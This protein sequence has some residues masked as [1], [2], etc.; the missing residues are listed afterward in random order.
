MKV[1]QVLIIA[2]VLLLGW[3]NSSNA[4]G[5]KPA[6][7][8][9]FGFAAS[10]ND[11]TVYMTNVQKI[12]AYLA[13]DRT[14]FLAN[15]EDYS[16]QLRYYLQSTGLQNFP[17]C[18]TMYAENESKAMKKFTALK[19]K[20]EKGKKKFDVKLISDSEFRYKAVTPDNYTPNVTPQVN[21][22]PAVQSKEA[23]TQENGNK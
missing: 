13:N 15:C 7:V 3:V 20:Y 4:K 8:Y 1:R 19:N 5:Y 23:Q 14:N 18:V 2:V 16:Y 10:F 22:T 12:D 21:T 6:K 11:S 17:T 9:M